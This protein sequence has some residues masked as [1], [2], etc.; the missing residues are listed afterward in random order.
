CSAAP[1]RHGNAVQFAVDVEQRTAGVAG[2]DA[3]V[4]L[5]QILVH[6]RVGDLHV[7]VQS[8]DHAASNGLLVA[9]GIAH[10]NH[11]LTQHQIARRADADRAELGFRLDLDD[12]Q[13]VLRVFG[14]P[15][16]GIDPAV[17][18][19][20]LNAFHALDYVR[21]GEDVAAFIDDQAGA[22]AVD[23]AGRLRQIVTGGL[24]DGFLAL[25]IDD[26]WRRLLHGFDDGG[27]RQF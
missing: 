12:G 3:G 19:R 18:Q 1:E 6:L 24:D 21:V 22:H 8:A 11:R 17:V 7:A 15:L 14:Q 10:S 5:D 13:V 27:A 4:G 20:D 16:G 2:I 9:V 23:A 26:G 25:D